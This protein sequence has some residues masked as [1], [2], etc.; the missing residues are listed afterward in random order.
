MMGGKSSDEQCG[1]E[2]GRSAEREKLSRLWWKRTVH[3]MSRPVYPRPRRAL[4]YSMDFVLDSWHLLIL[5]SAECKLTYLGLQEK[6][7]QKMCWRVVENFV[8]EVG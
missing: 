2:V 8:V 4:H 3:W 1:G 5:V 7:G 6:K